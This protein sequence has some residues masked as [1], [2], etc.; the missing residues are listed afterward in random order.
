MDPSRTVPG[1]H[2][3]TE[4]VAARPAL[5]VPEASL[6]VTEFLHPP[7]E[8]E[9]LLGQCLA[10][11]NVTARRQ[12]VLALLEQ[13]LLGRASQVRVTPCL[14]LDTG[15]RLVRVQGDLASMAVADLEAALARQ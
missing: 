2:R 5:I 3:A 8:L 4:V 14:V 10:R 12:R 11:L 7:G 9:L 6:F 13:P 15:S 1:A